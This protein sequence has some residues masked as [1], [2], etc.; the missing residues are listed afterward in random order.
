[1]LASLLAAGWASPSLA[2]SEHPQPPTS[3]S[4]PSLADNGS[5]A[6]VRE[7]RV[8]IGGGAEMREAQAGKMPDGYLVTVTWT[9]S[10][11]LV[12]ILCLHPRA[13]GC[14]RSEVVPAAPGHPGYRRQFIVLYGKERMSDLTLKILTHEICLAVA[15]SQNLQPDPCHGSDT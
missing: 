10:P 13:G 2:L 11:Q 1:L 9:D 7:I 14:Q 4:V 5:A 6:G 15:N 12:R 8:G 3:E